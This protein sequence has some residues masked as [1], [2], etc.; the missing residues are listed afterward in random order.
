MR[1]QTVQRR[2]VMERLAGWRP[3]GGR[4]HGFL[5]STKVC[6]RRIGLL[7]TI[8]LSI[9]FGAARAEAQI[10]Y[11]VS[12]GNDDGTGGTGG[13]LSYAIQQANTTGGTIQIT[14]DV[15]LTGSLRE[16]NA[17]SNLVT[18]VGNNHT[19][20][21]NGNQAFTISSG[22]IRISDL[23]VTG[24]AA[25][26][27]NGG[28]GNGGGGGGLGAGGGLYSDVAANVVI[29]NVQFQNNRAIGGNG[30]NGN[31]STTTGGSGGGFNANAN[32]AAA[33]SGGAA[34][35]PGNGGNG[36]YG[37]GGAGTG[38]SGTTGGSGNGGGSG[39]GN[40]MG[41][42]G[43]NGLGGAVFVVNQATLTISGGTVIAAS[44]TATG[45][46]GGT[47]TS[48]TGTN[49]PGSGGGLYVGITSTAILNNSGGD[50]TISGDIYTHGRIMVQGT[51]TSTVNFL[52]STIQT[53]TLAS[54]SVLTG[55]LNGNSGSLSGTIHDNSNVR[56]TQNT[57][58]TFNGNIDG[59]GSVTVTGTGTVIFAQTNTYTGGTTV[60]SGNLQGNT[61]GLQGVIRNNSRV[62]FDQDFDGNFNG[63]ITGS[64]GVAVTGTGIVTLLNQ[65]TYTGGTTVSSGNLRGS[66]Q[67]LQGDILNNAQVTFAPANDGLFTGTIHGTGGVNI[68]GNGVVIF[69]NANTYS[70][71][72]SVT[73]GALRGSTDAVQGDILNNSLVIFDQPTAGTYS[74]SMSGTGSVNLIGAGEVTFSGTNSYTGGTTVAAGK[75]RG[76]TAGIQG[77]V[78]NRTQVTFDQGFTGTYAGVMSGSGGVYVT[79]TGHVI[80]TGTNT[81]SG[82]TTVTAGVLEGN[83]TS[84]Q[85]NIANGAAVT[86]NDA[87]TGTYAGIISG[88]G[89]VNVIGPG[90]TIFTGTNTYTGGT[91]VSAGTLQ[92][93]SANIQGTITTNAQVSFVQNSDAVYR[94][95]ING[96]GDLVKSGTGNLSLTGD[97][98]YSGTTT[99]QQGKLSINGTNNS[100]VYVL[101]GGALG[102]TGFITGN[103]FNAGTV[104]PGNSI[105]T[106]HITG[107]YTSTSGS[108]TQ[109]EINSGG[110]VAGVNNDTITVTG[111][112]T[113]SG[114]TVAVQ[115]TT[116]SGYSSGTRYSFLQY[117]GTRTG[118]YGNITINTPFLTTTLNYGA[119]DV[120]FFINRSSTTYASTAQSYNQRQAA[121]YLD[122][123]STTATG[124]FARVLDQINLLS[125]SQ[126]RAAFDQLNGAVFGTAN[127][128]N[129]QN[130]T[131]MCILVERNS[132][133]E[134]LVGTARN[135]YGEPILTSVPEESNDLVLVNYSPD[136]Q[137]YTPVF[138]VVRRNGPLWNAWSTGYGS[139]DSGNTNLGQ[140]GA[141]GNI[142][143][144]YRYLTDIVKVG[145]FGAYNYVNVPMIVPRQ[146]VR[147]DDAQFGSYIRADDGVTHLLWNQ[148]FGFDDHQ[149]Y[150]DIAFGN[151]IRQ[152]RGS[153]G[154]WQ[155][156][157]YFEFGRQI[158][159]V[160]DDLEAFGALQYTYVRANGFQETGADSLNMRVG[161]TDTDA[162][163]SLLGLRWRHDILVRDQT[164]VGEL[165]GAWVHDFLERTGTL[166]STLVGAGGA[167]FSAA[168]I[169]YRRDSALLGAGLNW[170]ITNRITLAGNYDLLVDNDEDFFHV[171]SGSLQFRW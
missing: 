101:S 157:Q 86:F 1:N 143:S 106:M 71:G 59:N 148:S 96:T 94:G 2:S 56:F 118:T 144:V 99:I 24:A 137:T 3:Q 11:T 7:A 18:I 48:G 82:G 127:T 112:V 14:T 36:G 79:G 19:L 110:N 164:L 65:N 171:G 9:V 141:A 53:N 12:V 6:G 30:G 154:G 108:V 15:N 26:G 89:G 95:V 103:V 158:E 67:S 136:G 42:N 8:G 44:N 104:A 45:G 142:T 166:S 80:F 162:F 97:N 83:S 151:I 70:G 90:A 33:G 75:L 50:I 128:L 31:V 170:P 69:S 92:V 120:G 64:G 77:N 88:T 156:T 60:S 16:I 10:T 105:G 52:G 61:Q 41:G 125:A 34:G 66:T 21:G 32:T 123:N 107:N 130:A 47:G 163:R 81:Y 78:V 93:S 150:R 25:R 29:S 72:T 131:Y 40:G 57:T 117:T 22:T 49:G 87:T 85:G 63:S 43:G 160:G 54:I 37:G 129:V 51:G 98:G 155:T 153:Y 121:A 159:Q 76:T 38:A 113:L 132:N 169:H 13:T 68:A 145:F 20:S 140:Y 149:S 167:A 119:Q 5:R 23:V 17:T 126:A 122:R 100:D 28:N 165:R 114:G 139:F 55:T 134:G 135:E 124:D 109:I 133:Q 116:S 168:G 84:L 161:G 4:A 91:T 138:R 39:G 46:T 35:G 58:G 152:A 73:S 146:A 111:N 115:S 102:G 27:G 62:T 74:G 147:T